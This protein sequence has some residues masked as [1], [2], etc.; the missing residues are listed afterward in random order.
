MTAN[1]LPMEAPISPKMLTRMAG[2]NGPLVSQMRDAPADHLAVS[3]LMVWRRVLDGQKARPGA[4][5]L[6]IRDQDEALCV[7]LALSEL[8]AQLGEVAEGIG[9]ISHHFDLFR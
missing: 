6:T 2:R 4:G 3:A 5:V 1:Y 7:R 8:E 9:P